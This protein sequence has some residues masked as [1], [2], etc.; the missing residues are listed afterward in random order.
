M[1][2]TLEELV[3]AACVWL[4]THWG[5]AAKPVREPLVSAMGE[6]GFRI[7]YSLISIVSIVWVGVAYAAAPPGAHLWYLGIGVAHGSA[8][9]MLIPFVFVVAGLSGPNP[10]SIGS[11]GTLN[12]PD[13]VRGMMRITRHPG[14]WGIGLW[15]LLHMLS[16]G[17]TR[18]LILFGSMAATALIGTIFLD[19][20]KLRSLGGPYASFKLAT[21]NI[22]FAAI[23]DGRQ[24]LGPVFG[25]IGVVRFAIAIALYALFLVIH[26]WLFAVPVFPGLPV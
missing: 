4:A 16:N 13:P 3:A 19:G 1:T 7:A 2:G 12:D 20:K 14:L 8:V 9:L 17:D 22:P 6:G 15:G 24:R 5:L 11:E 26:G 18:S 21:S 25:E 23:I 10:S